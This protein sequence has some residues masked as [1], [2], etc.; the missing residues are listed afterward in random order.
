MAALTLN[1][2]ETITFGETFSKGYGLKPSESV[3]F[4][5]TVKV[6]FELNQG[7]LLSISEDNNFSYSLRPSESITLSEALAKDFGKGIAEAIAF[8]DAEKK[9]YSLPFSESVS[10][11]DAYVRRANAIFS[12]MIVGTTDLTQISFDDIVDSGKIVGY[13]RFRDF[14]PGDYTYQK[15]MFRAILESVN[16]DRARL[17]NMKVTVDVPDVFDRGQVTISA[18]QAATGVTVLFYR[19]FNVV[20]EVT[21][22]MKGGTVFAIP[23]VTPSLTGFSIILKDPATNA[24]VAGTVSWSAHGY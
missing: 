12:N 19:Q 9:N 24:G 4:S 23:N 18:A 8:T 15:A 13:D 20:P 14:I 10:V 7:E 21:V 17:T 11:I 3:T 16:A 22:T 2:S 1:A 6:D 5:D